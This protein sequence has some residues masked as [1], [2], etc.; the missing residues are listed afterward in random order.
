V[1]A[2]VRSGSEWEHPGWM[3][4]VLFRLLR[5]SAD[6]SVAASGDSDLCSRAIAW[7][8]VLRGRV[9]IVAVVFAG[10]LGVCVGSALGSVSLMRHEERMER[11]LVSYEPIR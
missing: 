9:A 1:G 11:V 4:G 8:R 5:V 2:A 7:R 6:W 10:A 3:A